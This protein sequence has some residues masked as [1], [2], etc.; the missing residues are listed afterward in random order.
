M[1]DFCYFS[2]DLELEKLFETK[3]G[4]I[5]TVEL[6]K[7]VDWFLGQKFNW[8]T[9]DDNYSYHLSQEA[10]TLDILNRFG[11]S[12]CNTS[13]TATPFQSGLPV[14]WIPHEDLPINEQEKMTKR[15]QEIVG[16]LTWLSIIGYFYHHFHV[17]G[18]PKQTIKRS[19][20]SFL[21][22]LT[23]FGIHH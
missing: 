8:Q 3:L 18:I 2:P 21:A 22:C 6:E 5:F 23:M 1:D 20:Q 12:Q 11:L 14:D 9:N 10:F 4:E 19:C 16:C 7:E 17:I 13:N 15:Y